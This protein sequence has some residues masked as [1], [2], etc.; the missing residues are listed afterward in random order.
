MSTGHSLSYQFRVVGEGNI[1]AIE[2]PIIQPTGA[3]EVYSPN[4]EQNIGRRHGRVRG[5]KTLL[6]YLVANE[7]GTHPLASLFHWIYFDPS[8]ERY[9][10]LVA[11]VQVKVA[12]QSRKNEIIDAQDVG[13][14]YDQIDQTDNT[15]VRGNAT[16]LERLIA[17]GLI[18]GMLVLT[19]LVVYRR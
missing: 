14:F 10:T 4:V 11:D 1:S 17:N 6:Y 15:L 12:G 9:D 19:I 8:T 3:F 13:S 5:A 18:I 16:G 2:E 7:P